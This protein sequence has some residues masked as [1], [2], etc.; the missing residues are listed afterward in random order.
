[1]SETDELYPPKSGGMVDTARKQAAAAADVAGTAPETD[2]DGG[3]FSPVRVQLRVP[4]VASSGTIVVA[5]AAGYHNVQRLVGTDGQRSRVIVMTLDQPVIICFSRIAA[6]DSR[7]AVNAAGLPA[8][9]FVLLAP[10]ATTPAV[11][12]PLDTVSEVWVAATSSTP[13]RVSFIRQSFSE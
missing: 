5:T 1:M 2:F 12:L 6:D 13:T 8:G 7:N 9:G 11:P 10:S 4:E 3:T